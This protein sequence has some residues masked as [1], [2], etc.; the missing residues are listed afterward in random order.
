MVAL[1][2]LLPAVASFATKNKS[3][4]TDLILNLGNPPF[5]LSLMLFKTKKGEETFNARRNNR[6][7]KNLKY[8]NIWE[9][10]SRHCGGYI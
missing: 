4:F 5:L 1:T 6:D 7:T 8:S 9:N 2:R 10:I 3:C